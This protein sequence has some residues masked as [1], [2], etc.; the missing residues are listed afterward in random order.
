[1]PAPRLASAPFS[2]RNARGRGGISGAVAGDLA[3][4]VDVGGVAAPPFYG[5]EIGHR[6]S[7]VEKGVPH[8]CSRSVAAADDLA[9]GVDGCGVAVFAAQS[10]KVDRGKAVGS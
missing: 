5:A 3:A 2:Q 7:I 1:M 6:T 8:A 9:A 4:R 10:A